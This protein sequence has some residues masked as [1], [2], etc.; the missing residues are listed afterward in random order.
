MRFRLLARRSP[1]HAAAPLAPRPEPPAQ[2]P[3]LRRARRE[4]PRRPEDPR[5]R[6]SASWW[7]TRSCSSRATASRDRE[8][9]RADDS[10]HADADRVRH[11]AVHGGR[12]GT[13]VRQGKLDWDK[14]V[15]DYLPEFR[16][17]DDFATLRATPRDLVTHRIGLPRHDGLWFGSDAHPRAALRAAPA[18]AVQPR[19]PRTRFQYNNLMYMTAG[20]LGG[21]I[22]GSIVGAAGED[23]ALRSPGHE[24]LRLLAG[25]LAADP[26]HAEGYQL[27]EKRERSSATPTSRRRPWAP[28]AASTPARAR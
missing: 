1:C 4:G 6:P 18:P 27:D 10:R 26:D 13:L 7:A 23:G 15:R 17:H 2:A 3:G 9:K 21:R 12:L 5:A 16:V 25:P 14:P 8:Q 22:A 28:R 11:Q 19:P 20:F 24:A